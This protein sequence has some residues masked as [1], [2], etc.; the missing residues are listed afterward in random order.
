MK[1]SNWKRR[2]STSIP[3]VKV[4]DQTDIHWQIKLLQQQLIVHFFLF[5]HEIH[6]EVI[7]NTLKIA[8]CPLFMGNTNL[9]TSQEIVGQKSY[10][11]PDRSL[12]KTPSLAEEEGEY[13]LTSLLPGWHQAVGEKLISQ[14]ALWRDMG[15]PEALANV[16]ATTRLWDQPHEVQQETWIPGAEWPLAQ[17]PPGDWLGSSSAGKD[18]GILANK[19][20]M[21][22]PP[23]HAVLKANHRLGCMSKSVASKGDPSLDTFRCWCSWCSQTATSTPGRIW[24]LADPVSQGVCV[25]V[26]PW[27]VLNQEHR[28]FHDPNHSP[29]RGQAATCTACAAPRTLQDQLRDQSRLAPFY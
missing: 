24:A 4:T 6:P 26:A 29:T 5:S 11:V 12:W 8:K 7:V 2:V 13:C 16:V 17:V 20:N 15:K 9:T 22:H 27:T 25:P 28:W 21:G 10:L 18:L 3:P 19:L 14:A 23:A 1:I